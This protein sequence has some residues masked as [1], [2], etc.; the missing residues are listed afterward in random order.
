VSAAWV[1]WKAPL[2]LVSMTDVHA[3]APIE[4]ASVSSRMPA[5]LTSTRIGPCSCATEANVSV[6]AT[7]S[8]TSHVASPPVRLT[9]T[10]LKPSSRRRWAIAA[11]MPR[12][13]PVT[14]AQPSSR[15]DTSLLLPRDDPGAPREPGAEC[16]EGDRVAGLEAAFG[17]GLGKRERDRRRRRVG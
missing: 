2:R 8:V 4:I 16:G 12:L 9:V 13:P 15:G 1:Q 7:G 11:P 17:L 6:T 3:S 14:T 10:T 5:L